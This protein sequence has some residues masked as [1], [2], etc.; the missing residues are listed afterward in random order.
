MIK[1]IHKLL[2][3]FYTFF[4]SRTPNVFADRGGGVRVPQVKYHWA[5]KYTNRNTRPGK[6]RK[7]AQ[8]VSDR[9]TTQDFNH[10][11]YSHVHSLRSASARRGQDQLHR[12]AKSAVENM[13]ALLTP[14]IFRTPVALRAFNA[15][16]NTML[17]ACLVT[18]LCSLYFYLRTPRIGLG[19]GGQVLFQLLILLHT[20]KDRNKIRRKVFGVQLPHKI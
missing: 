20:D 9:Q 11:H 19:G 1:Y 14:T 17:P 5:T 13:C 7:T 6:W 2:R 4:I 3:L 8:P 16:R 15:D 18:I 12:S 10:W